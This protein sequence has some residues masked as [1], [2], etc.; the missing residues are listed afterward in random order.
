MDIKKLVRDNLPYR[1]PFLFVDSFDELSEDL[2]IGRYRYKEDEFFYTGHFPG[3]PITPG[4]ILTETAAQIGLVGLGIYYLIKEEKV[5]QV[6]PLFSSAQVD[7]L[8]PVYPGEEV[9]V[10]SQKEY[11]RFNKLK[12]KVKMTNERG[13]KVCEGYLSGFMI[14]KS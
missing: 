4:V 12:C 5:G 1:R 3:N 14:E 10:H 13:E 7:F 9:R 11:F 2:A 6:V 8:L